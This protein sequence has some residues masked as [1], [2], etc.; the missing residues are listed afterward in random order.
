ML[1]TIANG[2][3]ERDMTIVQGITTK[4]GIMIRPYYKERR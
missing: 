4:D 2:G 1:V 3:I